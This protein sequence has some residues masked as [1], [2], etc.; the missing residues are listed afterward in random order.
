MWYHVIAAYGERKRYWWNL[1]RE[2]LFIKVLSPFAA[3]R[4]VLAKTQGQ[5]TLFNCGSI[6]QLKILGTSERLTKPPSGTYFPVELK[7]SRFIETHNVTSHFSDSI[8]SLYSKQEY[9]QEGKPVSERQMFVIMKFGDEALDSAYDGVIKP[10][11]SEFGYNALRV[12]EIENSGNITD[13]ILSAIRSSGLILADLTGER[14]NC[15]YEAGF[16]HL[17]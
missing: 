3:H 8:N 4:F 13:Q 15:Y 11:S 6:T 1:S 2:N 10:V 14:P 17:T 7:S 5:S 9:A 12:D 16:A